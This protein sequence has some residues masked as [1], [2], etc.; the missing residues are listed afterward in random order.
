MTFDTFVAKAPVLL[1][2][3]GWIIALLTIFVSLFPAFDAREPEFFLTALFAG[4]AAAANALVIPW[5][6]AAALWRFDKMRE[7]KP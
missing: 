2:R 1:F 3:L 6:A 5:A 4:G 7:E